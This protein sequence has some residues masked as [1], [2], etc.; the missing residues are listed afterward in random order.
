[1]SYTDKYIQLPILEF[2][3]TN[4]VENEDETISINGACTKY[5]SY[6]N[7]FDITRFEAHSYSPDMINVY[8]KYCN[9]VIVDMSCDEFMGLLDSH[10]GK[11]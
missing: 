11:S 2:H 3:S 8:T 10:V 5:F 7:V 9:P 1:M 6:I 4:E